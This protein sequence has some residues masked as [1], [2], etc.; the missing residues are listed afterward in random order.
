[1]S[2][3]LEVGNTNETLKELGENCLRN[4]KL[5]FFLTRKSLIFVSLSSKTRSYRSQICCP[6]AISHH[7]QT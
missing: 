2:K 1:M 5:G 3:G 4:Q 7:Q 6:K